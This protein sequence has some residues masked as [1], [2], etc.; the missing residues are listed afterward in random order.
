MQRVSGSLPLVARWFCNTNVAA[1]PPNTG[2]V[3]PKVNSCLMVLIVQCDSNLRLHYQKGD[4]SSRR[5]SQKRSDYQWTISSSFDW[6]KLVCLFLSL[7]LKS[8]VDC[9]KGETQFKLQFIIRSTGLQ[10]VLHSIG[11]AFC[12]KSHSK[13]LQAAMESRFH[14]DSMYRW[15][16]GVPGVQQCPIPPG[17]SF[18]YSFIADLYGTS[19][20]H[21][22]YSAQYVTFE[23]LIPF[24]ALSCCKISVLICSRYAGGLIGPMIIHGPQT[25]PYD[26]G[27]LKFFPTIG[28]RVMLNFTDK[29][30]IILSDWFHRDYLSIV[31]DVVGTDVT[32]VV[33]RAR[34][35]PSLS[36]TNTLI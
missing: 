10:R 6:S 18:T 9:F 11:T 14:T 34:D 22:H 12:R 17:G 21:S 32:K 16:D 19:W 15:M 7:S 28:Q 25:V 27:M 29:G 24:N 4:E 5:I 1:D 23:V 35:T 2:Y 33:S 36:C 3:L 8:T 30:P 26:I 20:Y 13:L 31:E